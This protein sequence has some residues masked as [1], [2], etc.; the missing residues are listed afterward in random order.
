[1]MYTRSTTFLLFFIPFFCL[2][3]FSCKTKPKES[4]KDEQIIVEQEEKIQEP[5][6]PAFVA[7]H[8]LVDVQVENPNIRVNLKYSTTDNFMKQVLY[9]SIERAYLQISVAR[10]LGKVQEYLTELDSSLFLLV[11][12]AVRPRSVQQKMWDGLDSIPLSRRVKFVSNPKNG[13]IHNYACAV[14]LTL[15][16]ASGKALDMGAE[17][18]DMNLIAYPSME[19]KFVL[20]GEL[21]VKQLRNRQLLRKVMR[22]QR[23]F[24][25]PTEWWHFNA[26]TRKLAK[27]KYEIVE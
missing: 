21:S 15:C 22:S 8:G 9:D 27:N 23:F 13:S 11:Y 18:D 7:Q 16:D 20:S 5:L 17:Y 12:D 10:R 6:I 26:H 1:M 19:K 4:P 3:L 24:N 2:T 25:I 14:D